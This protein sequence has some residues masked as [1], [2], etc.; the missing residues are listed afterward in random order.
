MK[1]CIR[2]S[3]S[4]DESEFALNRHGTKIYRRNVCRVCYDASRPNHAN[5]P[6]P[7]GL[8]CNRC[9][10]YKAASAFPRQRQCLYGLDP[11]CKACKLELRRVRKAKFPD[12][13][14]RIRLKMHYSL[15][16]EQYGQ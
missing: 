7:D 9:H 2:C 13:E 6:K 14:R 5:D 12:G 16:L 1:Q 8:T 3:I 4:K 10:R 11:V 15:T